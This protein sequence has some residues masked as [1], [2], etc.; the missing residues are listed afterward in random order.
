MSDDV[1][2][3]SGAFERAELAGAYINPDPQNLLFA[4]HEYATLRGMRVAR[5]T[6]LSGE[7]IARFGQIA[8]IKIWHAWHLYWYNDDGFTCSEMFASP[9]AAVER[10]IQLEGELT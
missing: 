6:Q 4:D 3:T 1:W 9:L 10:A 8:L 2:F 7:H 5:Y